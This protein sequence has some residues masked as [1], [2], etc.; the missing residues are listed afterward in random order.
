MLKTLVYLVILPV[1]LCSCGTAT[2]TKAKHISAATRVQ[3]L[4]CG[5]DSLQINL[6]LQRLVPDTALLGRMRSFYQG[7]EYSPAWISATGVNENAGNLINFLYNERATSFEKSGHSPDKL[8]E[9]HQMILGDTSGRIYCEDSLALQFEVLLTKSFFE[10]AKRNWGGADNSVS[11]QTSWFIARKQLDYD[12]LLNDYL[13]SSQGS[14]PEEPV[15]RQYNLLKGYLR[16]YN[17]I[18][19]KGGWPVLPAEDMRLKPGDISSVVSDMK[20]ML[21]LTEDLAEN[22]CSMI[23]DEEMEIAVKKFQKR[24]GLNENGIVSKTTLLAMCVP[25][26]ERIRTILINMERC[27]WV[28]IQVSGDY[29]VV[30][31]P[32]FRLHVF[33]NK[34][35]VW[36][37][38]VIVGKSDPLLHTVIFNDSV[39]FIVFNPYWNIPKNILKKEI[40]P[41]IKKDIGYIRRNNLEIIDNNGRALDAANL[42]W[43][44]YADYFPYLIRQRPCE[45]NA[46]GNLKFLFPNSYDMYMHDTPS[47]S[48]FNENDRDFSHGCIRLE[49]P[50]RLA[51]FLLREDTTWTSERMTTVISGGQETFVKLKKKTPVFIAY[52]TSWVDGAGKINF[53]NDIYG[54]DA[55]ME[56][57]LFVN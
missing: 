22:D 54:H 38:K 34:R 57:L 43:A 5:Q 49:Q 42:N 8:Q 4:M 9:L 28:P 24:H 19:L 25:I 41:A 51:E 50:L 20:R 37:C 6:F 11:K 31:I 44:G 30:N 45:D 52:F 33:R 23:F 15:Y 13:H 53:R 14:F 55:K 21:F 12:Q 18:A 10:F 3:R 47:K 17:A 2:S 39:E 29:L 26:Q 27:R 40:L 46:L 32:E 35:Q 16:K 7:R 48:L 56:K 36:S 1:L